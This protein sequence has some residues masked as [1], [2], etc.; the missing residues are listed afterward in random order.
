MIQPSTPGRVSVGDHYGKRHE[1]DLGQC[2]YYG[3]VKN[4]SY[5]EETPKRLGSDWIVER[6][7]NGRQLALHRI[8]HE[9]TWFVVDM[10]EMQGEVINL[11]QLRDL[12]PEVVS[13]VAADDD[14]RSFQIKVETT[15]YRAMRKAQWNPNGVCALVGPNG[16]GKTTLLTLLEFFRNAF[17]RNAP[18]AMDQMGGAYGLRSWN[19]NAEVPV[20]VALSVGGQRW[21]LELTTQGSTLT[22]KLGETVTD[23][24]EIVLS[25][26]PW[27]RQFFYRGKDIPIEANDDRMAIRIVAES[28]VG[29]EFHR[30]ADMVKTIR[31]YRSYNIWSLQTNG[32]RQGGDLY[33]HPSGQNLFTVLRNWRD[34]R[35][36]KPNY[37]FVVN[38]MREAFPEVFSDLDFHVAGLTVTVDVIDPHTN[39]CPLAL[40]PDGVITGLLHLTA[41]A[42]AVPSSFIAIDDFGNDLHPYAI[43]QLVS[44][45]RDWA[46]IHNLTICLASHSPV[47]L[48][49]FKEQ[50]SS[51]FVME[52]GLENRPVPLTDLFEEDWLSRFSLGQL[53]EY[54]EFGG[55]LARPKAVE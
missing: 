30:F 36:L 53:Y 16:S 12:Q 23:A 39:A 34:R 2:P 38:Q 27:G 45:F 3:V 10:S 51:V 14:S 29:D 7:Q 41:L 19:S 37:Q 9:G 40:A 50:P 46:E 5:L 28:S 25:R 55:Q 48:D 15:N 22:S 52:H 8:G 32:S 11:D 18:V 21:Q 6:L 44:A 17:L 20:S 43:R 13:L 1:L 42:G 24:G 33:L 4:P 49:E 31:V 35:D 47:L 26:P 54:G